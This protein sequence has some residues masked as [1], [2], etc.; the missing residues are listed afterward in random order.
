MLRQIAIENNVTKKKYISLSITIIIT[1]FIFSM[2]LL[3]GADSANLSSNLS[4][5]F[6]G[7]IDNIFTNNNIAIDIIENVV[8]KSAHVFEYFILGISYYFTAKYWG[9]SILKVLVIGLMTASIDELFQNIPVDRSASVIDVLVFDF[10]GFVLGL[11]LLLLFLNK[12]RKE[13]EKVILDLL[14][15]NEITPNKAYKKIYKQNQKINFT[16]NAHFIKLKIHIPDEKGV[17]TFLKI[18]FFLPIPL[19]IFRIALPFIKFDKMNIPI[20][21]EEIYK[22][23]NSKNIKIIV[24]ASTKEKIII[25]TI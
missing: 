25:K 24:N 18:L 11:G 14:Q 8:R 17:N 20:S 15:K 4:V 23:I 6:K 2:S 5:S 7:F 10:G 3:S 12:K 13:D 1:L 9:L 21:K 22:L 16:N 19:I